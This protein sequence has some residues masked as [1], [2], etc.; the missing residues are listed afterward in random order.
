MSARQ[1]RILILTALSVLI[2]AA[3]LFTYWK[4]VNPVKEEVDKLTEKI[5]ADMKMLEAIGSQI[6]EQIKLSTEESLQMQRQVPLESFVDQLIVNVRSVEQSSGNTIDSIGV[7]YSEISFDDWNKTIGTADAAAAEESKTD[8]LP[9]YKVSLGMA[10][11]SP[12]Y[13]R[14]RQFIMDLEGLERIVNVD[15][16]SFDSAADVYQLTVSVFY[17]PQLDGIEDRLP[18]AV[19]PGPAAKTNPIKIDKK[20]IEETSE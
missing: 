15:S 8:S 18:K 7:S 16:L 19:F 14:M 6:N 12:S 2:V 1:V 10:V 13:E 3:L 20:Q 9:L 4:A 11:Q 5:E 17:A